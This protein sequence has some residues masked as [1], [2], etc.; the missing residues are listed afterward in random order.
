MRSL[1]SKIIIL[2]IIVSA[3]LFLLSYD[4]GRNFESAKYLD[5]FYSIY[6]ELQTHYVDEIEPGDFLSFTIDNMLQSLD[7]YTQFIPESDIEQ[8]M[9]QTKG[10]YGG[11]GAT[12]AYIDSLVVIAKVIE[13]SPAHKADV[14]PGDIIESVDGR[15]LQAKSKTEIHEMLQGQS[16]TTIS[17]EINRKGTLIRKAIKRENIQMKNIPYSGMITDSI[18]YVKLNQFTQNCAQELKSACIEL[19]HKG[20][21]QLVLDLRDNPGGL[22]I[23][24]VAIANLFI[25]KGTKIVFTQGKNKIAD[26]VFYTQQ[27]AWNTHIPLA[28]LVNDKSASASEIVAGALQDLDRAVVI[29]NQTF[30]KGLVQIRKEIT[31]NAMLKL[32]TSKYYIPSGRCIQKIDYSQHTYKNKGLHIADSLHSVFYTK[33]KRPVADAGG[34]VPDILL[35]LDSLPIATQA[36]AQKLLFEQYANYSYSYADS[37]HIKP[38]TFKASQ[39][40][41][42]DF[43]SFITR[44]NFTVLTKSEELLKQILATNEQLVPEESLQT[45][46]QSLNNAKAGLYEQEKSQLLRELQLAI[47]ERIYFEKGRIIHT[48]STDAAIFKAKEVLQSAEYYNAILHNNK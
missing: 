20:A 6:I 19:T 7:P 18:G 38:E 33:N 31:H 25:D 2:I 15:P 46:L 40:E 8:F 45:L 10:E 9:I 21:K 30:G 41:F 42:D 48:L 23:E 17:M 34:I 1:Y 47:I 4:N 5:I 29:G 28:I 16:G 11:I 26:N 13:N 37:A 22:L 44:K 24:A 32:T 35:P 39:K 27:A 43:I 14:C 12:I 3:P 36:L